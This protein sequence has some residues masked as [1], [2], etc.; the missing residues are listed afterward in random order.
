MFSTLS[1]SDLLTDY[2]K[3][4]VLADRTFLALLGAGDHE[5]LFPPRTKITD[6]TRLGAGW[7]TVSATIERDSSTDHPA[8]VTQF[9]MPGD[10]RVGVED[11]R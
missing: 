9:H 7:V 10:A 11:V 1:A 6:V 5:I 8:M 2:R 4:K 3:G